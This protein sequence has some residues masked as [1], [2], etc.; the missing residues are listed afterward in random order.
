[1]ANAVVQPIEVA[2]QTRTPSLGTLN[3]TN[4]DYFSL[5][6]RLRDLIKEQF[7]GNFNDLFESS[8]AIM[9]VELFSF[10]ADTVNFKN[11]Q[12][13][14]EVYIDSVGEVANAFR[15]AK[16]VGFSPTPPIASRAMFSATIPSVLSAD[17]AIPG[18]TTLPIVT[19]QN[20]TISYQLY[21]ADLLGNPSL[22]EDIVIPAGNLTN[23]RVVG[24]EGSGRTD[25]FVGNGQTSQ[26]ITLTNLPVIYD[27]VLVAVDG[28]RWAQV[29]YFTDNQKR[30]EYRVEFDSNWTAF[31][32]FGSSRAGLIPSNGSQITVT[33][34]VG[35]GARGNIVT[36]AANIQR[37]FVVNGLGFPIPVT[38]TNY[39][40]GEF[41]YDG[42]GINEVRQKLP[43]YLRTQDRAVTGA[44][45]KTLADQYVTPYLGQIG[46][47]T[48]VLRN[49]GCSGNILDLYVL[50]RDGSA[51][52]QRAS[53]Q[54]KGS[55]AGFIDDRK[56]ATDHVCIRDGTVIPVD[57][58]IDVVVDKFFLKLKEELNVRLT[59]QANQFFSLNN[60]EYGQTLRDTD[61]I[62]AL[63]EVA[64]VRQF[65]VTFTTDDAGNSGD[66]VAAKYYEIV[67]PD[68]ISVSFTFQ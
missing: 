36:G 57:V 35:G 45:Y 6:T 26:T 40:K 52:L 46:K 20:E 56:M 32:V 4:Q 12:T 11:D 18:G 25:T 43:A 49:Q 30:R 58:A 65:D 61:L 23:T 5:K 27:S 7:L 22:G 1:V 53:D 38:F 17:L 68:S 34:R 66:L 10:A 48:A 44:D 29:D 50:A 28:I 42:D 39:T 64:E 67:R 47:S 15:I 41:G 9:L 60:W 54:M 24:L 14:N 37:N 21:P 62:K 51:G 2:Q 59:N 16:A 31:V 55:L 13:A 19:D 33:Y 3:Y 63:S 8:L